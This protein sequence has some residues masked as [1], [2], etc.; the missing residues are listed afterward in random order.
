VVELP[1]L[2]GEDKRKREVVWVYIEEA[3]RSSLN[4]ALD[5]D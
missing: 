1:E 3:N 2:V 4:D 5:S